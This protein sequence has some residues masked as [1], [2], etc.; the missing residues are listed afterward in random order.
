[1]ENNWKK[2]RQLSDEFKADAVNLVKSSHKPT[3]QIARELDVSY[4]A[5]KRWVA[6]ANKSL[7]PNDLS[8]SR[9]NATSSEISSLRKKIKELEMEKE[10]LKRFAAFWVKETDRK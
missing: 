6:L 3:S 9:S 8:D 2:G 4:S 7:E 10:I 1:M 5:L